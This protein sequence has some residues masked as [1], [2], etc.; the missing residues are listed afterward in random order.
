[1]FGR[2][3]KFGN[4][5]G[6]FNQGGYGQG[7]NNRPGRSSFL[8]GLF[9]GYMGGRASRGGGVLK[10]VMGVLVLVGIGFGI[11]T[12]GNSGDNLG[13]FKLELFGDPQSQQATMHQALGKAGDSFHELGE[14]A[15]PVTSDEGSY[16]DNGDKH[17]PS[18]IK[19]NRFKVLADFD[20][21]KSPY[22]LMIYN[23]QTSAD[24]FKKEVKLAMKE[25][26]PLHAIWIGD[27]H[28]HGN[29]S[30]DFIDNLINNNYQL[31]VNDEQYGKPDGG[32]FSS[33]TLINKNGKAI[34]STQRPQDAKTISQ[35]AIQARKAA[36]KEN[37][38]WD[39]P[40]LPYGAPYPDY[41]KAWDNLSNAVASVT[42]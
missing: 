36:V 12:W 7:F 4:N 24:K 15:I 29:P 5:R 27:V 28:D 8:G 32:Q 21:F 40:K 16:V 10:S 1:M 31:D 3:N 38:N 34:E 6:G 39:R 2:R 41:A 37:N 9:G 42:K 30:Y 25:G 33:L 18:W 14:K 13:K 26:V 23:D 19:D 17:F 20:K 11:Y 22:I 35:D